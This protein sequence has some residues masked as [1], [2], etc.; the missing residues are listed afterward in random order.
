MVSAA[1]PEPECTNGDHRLT[2][3]GVPQNSSGQVEVCA[4]GVWG[5]VCDDSWD[6]RDATVVC[7]QLGFNCECVECSIVGCDLL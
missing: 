1:M 2:V 5:V 3:D 4:F 6:L 7:R